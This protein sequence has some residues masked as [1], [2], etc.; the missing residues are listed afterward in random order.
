MGS[1]T[2]EGLMGLTIRTQS[3]KDQSTDNIYKKKT[4]RVRPG[5]CLSQPALVV[6]PDA[7][8]PVGSELAW[9][10]DHRRL[11]DLLDHGGVTGSGDHQP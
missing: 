11:P 6:F 7:Q 10:G 2:F 3:L 4:G 1:S 5:S 8:D 9:P